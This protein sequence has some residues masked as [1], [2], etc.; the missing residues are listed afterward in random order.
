MEIAIIALIVIQTVI[1]IVMLN[2]LA[3]GNNGKNDEQL[4]KLNEEIKLVK[5]S[6]NRVNEDI[7]NLKLESANS[8][9]ILRK[10]ISESVQNNIKSLGNMLLESQRNYSEMQNNSIKANGENTIKQIESIR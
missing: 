1:I 2:K 4:I 6:L 9:S 3:S 8:S 7:K 5:D 10:E